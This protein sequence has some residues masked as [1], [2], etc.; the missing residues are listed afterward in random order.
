MIGLSSRHLSFV[1]SA[2][3]VFSSEFVYIFHAPGMSVASQ[4]LVQ[5]AK[6]I[7]LVFES[8]IS[9][10]D[11]S[12]TRFIDITIAGQVLSATQKPVVTASVGEEGIDCILT[13]VAFPLP[14]GYTGRFWSRIGEVCPTRNNTASIQACHSNNRRTGK[15]GKRRGFA[16]S[17]RVCGIWSTSWTVH[18]TGDPCLRKSRQKR[19][20]TVQLYLIEGAC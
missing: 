2:S 18:S 15:K 12:W 17:K 11:N 9:S 14:V 1:Y 5:R 19:N 13:S 4:V 8:W 6:F 7:F 20:N 10:R 16:F 3:R